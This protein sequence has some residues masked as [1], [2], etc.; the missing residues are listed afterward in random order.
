MKTPRMHFRPDDPDQTPTIIRTSKAFVILSQTIKFYSFFHLF[1]FHLSILILDRNQNLPAPITRTFILEQGVCFTYSTWFLFLSNNVHSFWALEFTLPSSIL[2]IFWYKFAWSVG[3]MSATKQIWW[4]NSWTC[5]KLV[6]W[7]KA[8]NKV[9]MSKFVGMINTKLRFFK[10]EFQ[11]TYWNTIRY[12]FKFNFTRN[13]RSMA[14]EKVS[15]A[16][17]REF[18]K[19]CVN[20][21]VSWSGSSRLKCESRPIPF[22]HITCKV[23][24]A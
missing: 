24:Y 17:F 14:S 22:L 3:L 5:L 7:T 16:H 19:C 20:R 21:R 2:L 15:H 9:P 18:Q 11:P 13:K 6:A 4:N 1:A 10:S 23:M 8:S 12:L